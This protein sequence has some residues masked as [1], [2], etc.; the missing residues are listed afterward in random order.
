MRAEFVEEVIINPLVILCGD[1]PRD[2]A[3][4]DEDLTDIFDT[5]L[6]EED[7]LPLLELAM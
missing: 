2:T 3:M 5:E 7:V 1:L 6:V 4:S